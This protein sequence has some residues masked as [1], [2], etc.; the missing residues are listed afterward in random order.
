MVR[1]MQWGDLLQ[2]GVV[3]LTGLLV[4]VEVSVLMFGRSKAQQQQI[5]QLRT[6]L[7]G[8]LKDQEEVAEER[9]VRQETARDR[10]VDRLLEAISAGRQEAVKAR[11]EIRRDLSELDERGRA[12]RSVLDRVDERLSGLVRQYDALTARL[13]ASDRELR[14]V[15]RRVAGAERVIDLTR[16]DA[17]LRARR[18]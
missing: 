11:D 18:P 5:D 14:D 6:E 15:G 1:V 16:A 2:A 3:V 12:S 10:D 13:E 17:D 4:A 9:Q 8:L 7:T